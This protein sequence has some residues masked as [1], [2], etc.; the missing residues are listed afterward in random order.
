MNIK[1]IVF[2]CVA[3]S[4]LYGGDAFAG[5]IVSELAENFGGQSEF[6]KKRNRGPHAENQKNAE[7]NEENKAA[8]RTD[9]A[10][11]V[12]RKVSESLS[13]LNKMKKSELEDIPE[14]L[15]S[16][17]KPET[18]KDVGSKFGTHI[19][20]VWN[21]SSE[22]AAES[23]EIRALLDDLK[24]TATIISL[25]EGDLDGRKDIKYDFSEIDE[26][27]FEGII[28]KNDFSKAFYFNAIAKIADVLH[29]GTKGHVF[30]HGMFKFMVKLLVTDHYL[31]TSK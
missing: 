23:E 19:R 6:Y 30:W 20:A 29:K 27:N 21:L 2:T 9:D 13:I 17:G 28:D 12:L 24:N 3:V 25:S 7:R 16:G 10:I 26:N 11:S 5:S 18:Y 14:N 31:L 4:L 22:D 8:S 1:K 15:F